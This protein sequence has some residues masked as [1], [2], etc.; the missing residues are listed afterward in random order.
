M[1]AFVSLKAGVQNSPALMDEL[2]GHVVK[3]DRPHDS[4]GRALG[5]TTTLADSTVVARLKEQ[6]EEE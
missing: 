3:K 6:Y 1:C 5:D 2:K 4:A